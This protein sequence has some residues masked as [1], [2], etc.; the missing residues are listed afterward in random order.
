MAGTAGRQLDI[1]VVSHRLGQTRRANFSISRLQI[2]LLAGLCASLLLGGG[3]F[4][5]GKLQQPAAGQPLDIAALWAGELSEQRAQ[6][7]ETRSLIQSNTAALSRRLA[8]LNAQ[9]IR[10]DAAGQR[11][12]E[13]ADLD[14][15]EFNF[16][17]LPAI[18]G[19]QSAGGDSLPA[20][21]LDVLSES[22]N[23]VE[24]RLANRERQMRVLEDLLLAS[25]LQEQV[26]PSGWPIE[27]GWMSSKFGLRTDPFTGRRE[28]H[29]GIDFAGRDG[30]A[31]LAVASGVVTGAGKRYGYGN[32]VEINH[33]N[34]Y[35]TRYGH[36]KTIK[37]KVG[38]RVT[39]GQLIAAMGSTGRS[40]GPHVHFEVLLNGQVVNPTQYIQ[41]A[42]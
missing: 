7:D 13:V 16:D 2:G 26:E 32:L 17:E 42:R 3:I 10:L 5:G 22:L 12:T 11:L 4:L 8:L 6:L 40:T 36:N 20:P 33:G 25:R 19:P 39:K 28:Q 15:G 34:G 38:E 41:A 37:V 1:I 29:Y 35:V 24:T 30:S 23:E 9:M 14:A 21:S 27:K 31:V 18:G